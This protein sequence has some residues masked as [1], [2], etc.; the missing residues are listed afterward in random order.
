MYHGFKRITPTPKNNGSEGPCSLPPPAF[1][2]SVSPP[3]PGGP[4]MRRLGNASHFAY[5]NPGVSET[6]A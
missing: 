1:D 2:Y 6:L 5:R 3:P 4:S